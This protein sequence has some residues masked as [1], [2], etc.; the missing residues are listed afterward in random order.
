MRNLRFTMTTGEVGKVLW[1][2]LEPTNDE[3]VAEAVDI[4]T[5][6]VTLT[7]SRGGT[8]YIDDVACTPDPDQ[9]ANIGEGTYTFD[10]ITAALNPGDYSLRIKADD[11]GNI[12]YFPTL[13]SRTYGLLRVLA[14]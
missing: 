5:W 2:K 4:S 11:G 13:A 12:Y 3:G 14:Q 1:F 7:A 10:A 9:V 8:V 6:T